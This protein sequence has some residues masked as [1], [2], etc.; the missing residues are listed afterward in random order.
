MSIEIKNGKITRIS[1]IDSP[2]VCFAND[3][4]SLEES[5]KEWEAHLR[6]L[7]KDPEMNRGLIKHAKKHLRDERNWKV[8]NLNKNKN[9]L[10]GLRNIAQVAVTLIGLVAMTAY[11]SLIQWI[12]IL[13]LG[14]MA[15]LFVVVLIFFA[16]NGVRILFG[17]PAIKRI[18][19]W[20]FNV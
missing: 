9:P 20:P 13:L 15:L 12:P 3:K 11:M 14:V 5:R 2:L 10:T 7:K 16:I 1:M 6:D 17:K 8:V 18:N 19:F 4:E